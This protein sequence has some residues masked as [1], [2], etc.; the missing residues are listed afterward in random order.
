M[1][2][3]TQ[4]RQVNAIRNP[5]EESGPFVRRS[6]SVTGHRGADCSRFPSAQVRP[7]PQEDGAGKATAF[8]VRGSLP[9]CSVAPRRRA[10]SDGESARSDPTSQTAVPAPQRHLRWP[11]MAA[12]CEIRCAGRGTAKTAQ[13]HPAGSIRR[14]FGEAFPWR[15][16]RG[17]TRGEVQARGEAVLS[18]ASSCAAF[19]WRA[20]VRRPPPARPGPWRTQTRRSCRPVP[21]RRAAWRP[22]P[23]PRRGRGRGWRCRQG[24]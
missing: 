8:A 9:P 15:D 14:R 12:G 3:L 6:R 5:A 20:I 22:S 1:P 11:D 7:R 21:P 13:R 16:P 18:R 17:P 4:M 24:Q 23:Q 19:R 10:C 2:K